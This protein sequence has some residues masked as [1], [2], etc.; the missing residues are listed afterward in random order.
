[1]CVVVE[2]L[3]VGK[4]DFEKITSKNFK[5]GRIRSLERHE[6]AK[7]GLSAMDEKSSEL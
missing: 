3:K 4:S 6:E 5:R 1:M 2:L 7:T